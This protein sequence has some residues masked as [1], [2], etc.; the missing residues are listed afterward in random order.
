MGGH[1]D[2]ARRGAGGA[3]LGDRQRAAEADAGARRSRCGRARA[4]RPMCRV[5]AVVLEPAGTAPGLLVGV[6][7]AGRGAARAAAGAADDVGG[8]GRRRRRWPSCCASA[9]TLEQRILRFFPLPEPQIAATLRE[10]DADAL[11][12]E[13]TTCLRRGELEV[14]TVF[15]AGGRGRLRGVRGRA[16]RAPRGRPVLRRRRDDRR[17]HRA[18]LSGLDDRHGRVLH[19]RADG[20]AADRP[21]RLLGLRAGWR[22]RVLQRGQDGV[23]RTCQLTLI[24]AHGA[25]SPEVAR[26]LAAGA[27]ARFGADLGIGI[28]GIAGP[29]GGSEDK[30]VGTVC[31]SC[32]AAWGRRGARRP[33]ARAGAPTCATARRRWR[34]T[35]C[36]GCSRTSR[37][38]NGSPRE[39]RRGV[40][41]AAARRPRPGPAWRRA[42][43]LGRSDAGDPLRTGPYRSCPRPPRPRPRRARRVGAAADPDVGVPSP[44][45][46]HVT[47]AFLG[48][49]PPADVDL[50][51]PDRR[52][53]AR[54]APQLAL[55][56][57][58][59]PRRT[60]PR[61]RDHDPRRS[62]RS[63]RASRRALEAA[64]VYTPETRPFRPHVTLARLRPRTKRPRSTSRRRSI[65]S[66]S[67]ARP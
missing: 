10:I 8:R 39:E 34:S 54:R 9:G 4:S 30:P 66:P 25:V 61:R 2:G 26:A 64:G 44:R 19:G 17:G 58:A 6:R 52:S 60:R 48:I 29:G 5:G 23:R 27:R 40:S 43:R 15:T 24:A 53:R 36:V 63:R 55:G 59:P 57:A 18:A 14:A 46:L 49:R 42:R 13:V 45:V 65:P 38:A 11:P 33:P 47:L 21:R 28:T 50:D 16:A 31:I 35:C 32:L 62:P 41:L 67:T 56:N 37:G 12:F 3:D 7:A 1:D 22:G 51:R 20:G